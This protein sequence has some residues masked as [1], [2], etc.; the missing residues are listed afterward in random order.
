MFAQAIP[1][2]TCSLSSKALFKQKL[3][4]PARIRSVVTPC[5]VARC[6]GK[7]AEE[8]VPRSMV[9]V[10]LAASMAISPITALVPPAHA[11]ALSADELRERRELAKARRLAQVAEE[12]GEYV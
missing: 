3:Q 7:R 10:V 8:S 9:A 5:T 2:S 4:R 6:E 11:E 1:S 12:R